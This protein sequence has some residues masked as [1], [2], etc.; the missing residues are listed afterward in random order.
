MS[1]ADATYRSKK[2]T[3]CRSARVDW[4]NLP[5]CMQR[6][7]AKEPQACPVLLIWKPT[8]PTP[9][10]M[11]QHSCQC[12]VPYIDASRDIQ[13][14]NAERTEHPSNRQNEAIQMRARTRSSNT[15]SL[16]ATD[17]SMEHQSHG[18]CWRT[19]PTAAVYGCGC[20][21]LSNPSKM[22]A[23]AGRSGRPSTGCMGGTAGQPGV[24]ASP[25][26]GPSCSTGMLVTLPSMLRRLLLRTEQLPEPSAA[27]A[28][29]AAAMPAEE[30]SAPKPS[31]LLLLL[32]GREPPPSTAD[33]GG[34]SS[35]G[36]GRFLTP[37]LLPAPLLLRGL[38]RLLASWPGH[39]CPV[40]SIAAAPK[41]PALLLL[42]LLGSAA[43]ALA[44]NADASAGLQPA[45]GAA[46]DAAAAL[47]A[48]GTS[49]G[50]T[51]GLLGTA[52]CSSM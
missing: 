20:G 16:S 1:V 2:A 22:N 33:R 5:R 45:A 36:K 38:L 12:V 18:W 32:E 26:W 14:V 21:S 19:Q 30:A 17:V 27:S 48:C 44:V 25:S 31:S 46:A 51:K 47:G 39:L 15:L 29:A 11:Q 43:G 9:Y 34:T 35:A 3:E 24:H 6:A 10:D 23:G 50:G 49:A 40:G 52:S 13:A 7:K 28:A 42:L 41:P 4:T 8:K 37:P